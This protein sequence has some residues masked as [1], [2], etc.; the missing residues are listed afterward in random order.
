[1]DSGDDFWLCSLL[2]LILPDGACVN[3]F[4]AHHFQEPLL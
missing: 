2:L 1:M 3:F 4:I